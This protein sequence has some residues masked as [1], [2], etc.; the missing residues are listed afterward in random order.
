M[1][2]GLIKHS[3]SFIGLFSNSLLFSSK[4]QGFLLLYNLEKDESTRI[5]DMKGK[6]DGILW[7]Y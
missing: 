5:Y 1:P 6:L 7:F 3:R 2:V 4:D